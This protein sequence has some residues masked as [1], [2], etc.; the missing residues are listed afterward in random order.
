MRRTE[1]EVPAVNRIITGYFQERRNYSTWRTRGTGDYLLMY[2][3]SGR[4]RVGFR[5]TEFSEELIEEQIVT[6]GDIVLIHPNTLHDYGT[7][8]GVEGWELLW[9]HFLPYPH[10]QELLNWPQVRT[11]I[12]GVGVL[13]LANSEPKEEILKSLWEMHQQ[14]SG[15][16]ERRDAFAMNALEKALLWCDTINPQ[17]SRAGLDMRVER[18]LQYLRE[19]LS[20]PVSL[21]EV[22][23]LVNLS[24]SH[25]SRLFRAQTGET[26]GQFIERERMSRARQLLTFTSRS[27]SAISADVGFESPFYFTLRFRKHMGVSPREYRQRNA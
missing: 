16:Q 6:E 23:Q 14:G 26:P 1:T 15:G 11:G 3:L 13:S 8:R 10:W 4:G 12:R 22:A 18:A 2:T 17:S 25:L 5:A 7:A 20:Q 27:I 21:A 9:T 19:H 24:P